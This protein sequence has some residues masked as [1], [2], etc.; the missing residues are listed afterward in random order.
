MKTRFRDP[1][2]VVSSA[3]TKLAAPIWEYGERLLVV[4]ANFRVTFGP[5]SCCVNEDCVRMKAR[6]DSIEILLIERVE[7]ATDE[8]FLAGHLNSLRTIR[9]ESD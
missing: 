1:T 9:I 5:L 7:V 8:F 4:A 6:H 3:E 2:A